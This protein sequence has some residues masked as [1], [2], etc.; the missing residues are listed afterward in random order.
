MSC[1]LAGKGC[2]APDQKCDRDRY[3]ALLASAVRDA[4]VIPLIG[5]IEHAEEII[6]AMNLQRMRQAD[7][8]LGRLLE[9]LEHVFHEWSEP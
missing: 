6:G 9:E 3:K 5:G 2:S 8:S 7:K 4:G 1:R